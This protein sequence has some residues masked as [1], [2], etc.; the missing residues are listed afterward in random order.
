MIP[1][2]FASNMPFA[3]K[4]MVKV[5]KTELRTMTKLG[6]NKIVQDK[7][8]AVIKN[9]NRTS[10]QNFLIKF[11]I[12]VISVFSPVNSHCWH[13]GERKVGK[14]FAGTNIIESNRA[15][16]CRVVGAEFKIGCIHFCAQFFAVM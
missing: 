4:K 15:D 12:F 9:K 7:I 1:A 11:S 2:K 14:A 8:P 6:L 3:N 10:H 16:H 13:G 5:P